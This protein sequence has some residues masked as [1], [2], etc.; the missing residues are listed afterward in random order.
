MLRQASIVAAGLVIAGL[1]VWCAPFGADDSRASS[2]ASVEASASIPGDADAAADDRDAG[3]AEVDDAGNL[4]P[5][6]AAIHAARPL[7]PSGIYAIL[8]SASAQLSVHCDM[9]TANGGGTLIARSVAKST[10]SSFGWK[11]S[12]GSL[13]DDTK[14]YS[15]DATK[16]A[17]FTEVL[18]GVRQAG[19]TWGAPVYRRA[20]PSNFLSTYGTTFPATQSASTDVTGMCPPPETDSIA[21]TM[22]S[23][24]GATSTKDHFVFTDDPANPAFGLDSENWNTNGAYDHPVS[25]GYSGLLT[26]AEG[27]IFV[28]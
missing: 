2:D 14:P 8:P 3:V 11:R 4:F 20:L 24:A 17:P 12:T 9:T 27:M 16:L 13:L 23:L 19:K 7:V 10:V 22:V 6:C 1:G 5:S 18:F 21:P 25:C 28:R 15:V 26:G